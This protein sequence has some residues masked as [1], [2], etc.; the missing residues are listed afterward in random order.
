MCGVCGYVAPAGA[1]GGSDLVNRMMVAL[2]HRGPDSSG[3]YCSEFAQLGVT[4]LEIL[5]RGG[6]QQP[7]YG[8]DGSLVLIANAEI[9]NHVELRKRLSEAGH[10]FQ[11]NGDCEVILHLYEDHG[12]DLVHHLR[13]MFAFALWDERRCRLLLVRDRIGEKPLYLH[14]SPGQVL[15]AS[16]LKALL[17]TA[18]V[19]F[20][21]DPDQVDLYFHYQY[22]PEPGT[23]LIGVRKLPAGHLLTIDTRP[24][25]VRERCYWRLAEAPP[26]DADPAEA[27]G[28]ELRRLAPLIVRSDVPIGVALSGGLDSSVVAALA[29]G[30]AERPVHAFSV[31]YAGRPHNDERADARALAARLGMEFHEV[32]LGATDAVAA[33]PDL[34]DAWDDPIAD[35]TGFCYRA[36]AQAA[37]ANGV[38]VLL[39]GQGG[40][41]LF[42]GYP[43]VRRAMRESLSRAELWRGRCSPG[44]LAAYLRGYRSDGTKRSLRQFVADV[45][46][47]RGQLTFYDLDPDFQQARRRMRSYYGDAVRPAGSRRSASSL[48]TLP[49]TST[50][51]R[52]EDLAIQITRLIVET[53]LAEN[54]I[55]QGD[56]LTMAN[57][58]ELRLPLVDH[59]LIETVIGLRKTRSDD[60]E[61]PKAWL[62]RVARDL[63]PDDVVNRPKRPFSPPLR[64]WHDRLVAAYGDLLPGGQL[65]GRAVLTDNAARELARGSL[66]PGE[67]S[68]LTFKALVLEMWCRVMARASGSS[69]T[70]S[71]SPRQQVS[72]P[73]QGPACG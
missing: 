10:K 45:V 65:T 62:R 7:I 58:V 25:Q 8:G 14:E 1:E 29:A 15:F 67:G 54:G 4:Q 33:F 73:R 59:R 70:W 27:I 31:G 71:R 53:Y 55:T 28:D 38:P 30:N 46:A 3:Q 6:S 22:I 49:G 34:V 66:L 9:Y 39:Q 64:Q 20:E 40:D 24:W 51:I 19:P 57:S 50:P 52:R 18:A 48:F 26:L 35:V 68:S 43:W 72:V 32:E 13:G 36:I 69:G 21:L 56:R 60:A 5:D 44:A 47:P 17:S 11:T 37:R 12:V 16:E 2:A 41:E 23:P 63:L 61:P 42:W